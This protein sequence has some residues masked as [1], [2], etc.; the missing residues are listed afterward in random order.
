MEGFYQDEQW[1]NKGHSRY[2]N[3]IFI[4]V[5]VLEGGTIIGGV[6]YWEQ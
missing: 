4:T 2:R 6:C 1:K 3:S 5:R